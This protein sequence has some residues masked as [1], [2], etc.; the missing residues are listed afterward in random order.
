MSQPLV[1]LVDEFAARLFGELDYEQEG[2][3]AEKFGRLYR[4]VR[5]CVCARVR[6][7]V[8]VLG[9]LSTGMAA[10]GAV[11][12]G[13]GRAAGLW[14]GLSRCLLPCSRPRGSQ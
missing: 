10:L 8:C 3:N 4:C 14:R 12:A 5:V 2:R 13:T 1:P 11:R 6:V 7:C 9:V